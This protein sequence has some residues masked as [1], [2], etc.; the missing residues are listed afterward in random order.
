[1]QPLDVGFGL[2]EQVPLEAPAQASH[3]RHTT[4]GSCT[5]KESSVRLRRRSPG[6]KCCPACQ[7][8]IPR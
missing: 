2:M 1:M 8:V 7:G 5:D 6:L 4:G 3:G